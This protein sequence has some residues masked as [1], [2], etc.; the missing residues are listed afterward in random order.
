MRNLNNTYNILV[1]NFNFLNNLYYYLQ[2]STPI[3]NLATGTCLG[4]S[5]K[6]SRIQVVMNL[7]TKTDK[8]LIEWNLVR[9]VVYNVGNV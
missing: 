2:K 5:Y 1:T 3:Y 4:V 7:C 8:S 9:S 6:K